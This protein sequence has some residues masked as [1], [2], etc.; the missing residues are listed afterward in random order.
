MVFLE[1]RRRWTGHSPCSESLAESLKM[2]ALAAGVSQCREGAILYLVSAFS[3]LQGQLEGHLE[4]HA[5]G[6]EP[7][8]HVW[9]SVIF[10][11]FVR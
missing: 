3:H 11:F 6:L 2:A 4:V 7:D 5:C 10:S 9:D 1:G 8:N